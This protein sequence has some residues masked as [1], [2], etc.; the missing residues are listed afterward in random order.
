MKIIKKGTFF[1]KIL[2]FILIISFF[3]IYSIKNV[4]A[5]NINVHSYEDDND[6]NDNESECPTLLSASKEKNVYLTFDDGPDPK[7]THQILDTLKQE[8]IKATFFVI[9]QNI[10]YYKKPF[11]RIVNEGHSIGLHSYTHELKDVYKS[12]ESFLSEM[13]KSQSLIKNLT[14]QTV[15]ILRFPGG[16]FKRLTPT[17]LD[18]LH[19]KNY[20]IYDW[21]ATVDDGMKPRTSANKLVENA[22]SY[23]GKNNDIIVLLHNRY[24][25]STTA[26]ALPKLIKHYKSLGYTFKSISNDTPEYYFYCK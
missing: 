18:K 11:N 10:N 23:K 4:Y 12:D 8:N 16:T 5:N 13:E 3:N 21:H 22:I 20:K 17:L 2:I 19:A 26:E 25:N 1:N 14:G 24:N 15:S 9:G 7:V 6:K